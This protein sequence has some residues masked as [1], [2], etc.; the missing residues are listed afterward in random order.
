MRSFTCFGEQVISPALGVGQNS[1]RES[2]VAPQG[3]R[4]RLIDVL[5]SFFF[6][7]MRCRV[8]KCT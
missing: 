5:E 4:S 3:F 2:V 8:F 1:H 6:A 7:G